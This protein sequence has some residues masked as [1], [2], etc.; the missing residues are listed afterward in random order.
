MWKILR[1]WCEI[2]DWKVFDVLETLFV[3]K[4]SIL[5]YLINT[6]NL[7]YAVSNIY[8]ICFLRSVHTYSWFLKSN[9]RDDFSHAETRSGT[10]K[11]V[12]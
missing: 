1:A 12:V 2:S 11:R 8:K 6:E 10:K 7:V 3:Q 4:T 9:W 5:K